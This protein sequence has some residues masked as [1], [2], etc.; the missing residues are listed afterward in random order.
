MNSN[1]EPSS[2]PTSSKT[3]GLF[4]CYTA[5]NYGDDLML[6][7]FSRV[8][9]EWGVAHI[10]YCAEEIGAQLDCLH[11]DS[12]GYFLDRVD[13]LIF[14]GGG[15]F[16]DHL[17]S[18]KKFSKV[19]GHVADKCV[20]K[21]IAVYAFSAGGSGH[22][23]PQLD[24]ERL[25]FLRTLKG[26]TLRNPEDEK[27]IETFDIPYESCADVVWCLQDFFT[28]QESRPQNSRTIIG[29]DSTLVG[30]RLLGIRILQ[31]LIRMRPGAYKIVEVD[32][33]IK[34][35]VDPQRI[36]YHDLKTFIDELQGIDIM[37][38]DRLHLNM[39]L[40]ALG[41]SAV[42]YNGA[43]KSRVIFERYKLSRLIFC[44][45]W[46]VFWLCCEVLSGHLP[47]RV[48]KGVLKLDTQGL[49]DDARQHFEKFRTVLKEAGR[50]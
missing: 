11:N 13:I 17:H 38:S 20:E 49:R 26:M 29:I 12:I 14:G 24:P 8:L 35:K 36:Q 39:T 21:G 27:F 18:S 50:L 44:G 37:I 3:V 41:K 16:V 5:R 15:L 33:W 42:L 6:F 30:Q 1:L 23:K 7:M 4:G 22:P 9:S 46:K 48:R 47:R 45:P 32:Q 28:R 10:A 31:R 19:L 2:I 25:R 43:P 40:L 34:P